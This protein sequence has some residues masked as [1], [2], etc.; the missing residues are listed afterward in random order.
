[1]ST[2]MSL[3]SRGTVFML[4]CLISAASQKVSWGSTPSETPA[5]VFFSSWTLSLACSIRASTS[6]TSLASSATELVA[7]LAWSGVAAPSASATSPSAAVA[8]WS[9]DATFACSF[10]LS[11]LSAFSFSSLAAFLTLSFAFS[12]TMPMAHLNLWKLSLLKPFEPSGTWMA[13]IRSQSFAERVQSHSALANFFASGLPRK[14]SFEAYLSNRASWTS[15]S[16][17]ALAFLVTFAFWSWAS[18]SV[19][20]FPLVHSMMRCS[21]AWKVGFSDAGFSADAWPGGAIGMETLSSA[22]LAVMKSVHTFILSLAAAPASSTVATA[23]IT[24]SRL[25][26]ALSE[27]GFASSLS[28][29]PF[30]SASTM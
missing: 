23:A 22:P 29:L 10:A 12:R 4:T 14:P 1:M 20:S 15:I 7:T 30:S 21:S 25:I 9:A 13:K 18:F 28:A 8:S 26:S 6:S 24:S 5:M 2:F 3:G 16:F 17:F 27:N 19:A 11:S